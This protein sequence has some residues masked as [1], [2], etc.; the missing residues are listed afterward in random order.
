MLTAIALFVLFS[1][2]ISKI[3][4]SAKIKTMVTL[5]SAYSFGMYLV[6]DFFNILFN[7]IGFTT[8]L[9]KAVFSVPLITIC[10]FLGSF[11]VIH[12]LRKNRFL[13]EY[14]T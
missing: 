9:F 4:F 6:H 13:R 12:I 7:R 11:I 2:R 10:V 5:V 1:Q 14:M 3:E 8:L